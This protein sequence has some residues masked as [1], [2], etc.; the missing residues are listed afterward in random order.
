VLLRDRRCHK[1]LTIREQIKTVKF[2]S[3]CCQNKR[4]VVGRSAVLRHRVVVVIRGSKASLYTP[5][6]LRVPATA[7]GLV[8]VSVMFSVVHSGSDA[9]RIRDASEEVLIEQITYLQLLILCGLVRLCALLAR[10][11]QKET[12]TPFIHIP[13]TMHQGCCALQQRPCRAMVHRGA[14]LY[15][16]LVIGH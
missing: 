16:N 4:G 6:Q 9:K 1:R 5:D 8:Y 14:L 3:R 7:H 15:M 2:V 13:Q 10:H 12:H 11:L